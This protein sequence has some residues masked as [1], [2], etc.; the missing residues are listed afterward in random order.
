MSLYRELVSET[1]L[2]FRFV[3]GAFLFERIVGEIG[4]ETSNS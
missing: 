3:S 2:Y 4:K 1:K